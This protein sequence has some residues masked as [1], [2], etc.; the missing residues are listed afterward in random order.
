MLKSLRQ[1]DFRKLRE[2]IDLI[3][4]SMLVTAF[5][6]YF[7]YR[8]LWILPLLSPAGYF[9]YRQEAR[10]REQKKKDELS[11]EF[12]ELIMSVSANLQA[13]YAIENALVEAKKDMIVMY[14]E[15]SSIVDELNQIVRGIRNNIPV[16]EMLERFGK[17]SN[18]PE[19]EDFASVFFIA[20]RTGGDLVDII[21]STTDVISKKIEVKND[22]KMLISAKMF[23]QQI[24]NLVPF[25]IILYISATSP[26]FFD[27]MYG[28]ATGI[29]I[30]TICLGLYLTAYFMSQ[31]MIQIRV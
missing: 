31:K 9:F 7:F 25:G 11:R 29:L 28:N 1:Q 17:R 10:K 26:G 18:I 27:S 20:K 30:M 2:N 16:E 23:E 12:K 15:K 14:G 24:M 19:I 22:I 3:L 4:L 6:S 13:G 21:R 5:L 8:E